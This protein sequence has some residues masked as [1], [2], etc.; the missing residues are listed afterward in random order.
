MNN[1]VITETS[2]VPPYT[3]LP[4]IFPQATRSQ[5]FF[6]HIKKFIT[7]CLST[8]YFQLIIVLSKELAITDEWVATDCIVLNKVV[9]IKIF[10]L[11]F[12]LL[13]NIPFITPSKEPPEEVSDSALNILNLFL[14]SDKIK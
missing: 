8:T 5:A 9:L 1:L 3:I 11:C 2:W 14:K 6:L 4:F 7:L 10:F 13:L 12:L